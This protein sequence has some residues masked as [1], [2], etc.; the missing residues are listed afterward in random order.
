MKKKPRPGVIVEVAPGKRK[1]GGGVIKEIAPPTKK[2]ARP[3]IVVE[4]APP[5]KK[6]K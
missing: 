3:G 6:K 4:V 5:S 2:K 1:Y